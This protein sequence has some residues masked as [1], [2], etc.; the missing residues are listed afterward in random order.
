MDADE[1]LQQTKALAKHMSVYQPSLAPDITSNA[2]VSESAI[3]ELLI[4]CEE[5]WKELEELQ[6]KLTLTETLD[7]A[8][9]EFSQLMTR[10]KALTSELNQW[11]KREPELL[12]KNHDVLV[13]V[14]KE[15]LQRVN[16]ELEMVLSCCQTKNEKLN[17]DLKSEQKWLEEQEELLKAVT[18][19]AAELQNEVMEFSESRAMQELKVKI[20]QVKTYQEKLLEDLGEFIEEHFPL[21]QQQGNASKKKKNVPQEPTADL[22]SLQEILELL[23][24]KILQTPHE[25]YAT[26]DNTFWPPYVEMLLRYGVVLRHPEDPNRIRMEAFHQ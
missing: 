24:N 3:E 26:I 15:E 23:M 21:P 2:V 25:P 12:S 1:L 9:S 4:E 20:N 11:Q 7:D 5:K 22:I 19:K 18:D 13:A 8:G 6:N 10:V 17:Q 14:G 16:K